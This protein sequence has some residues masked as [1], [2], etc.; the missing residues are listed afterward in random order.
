MSISK[1]GG[2]PKWLKRGRAK[3]VS[4]EAKLRYLNPMNFKE[5]NARRPRTDTGKKIT[6]FSHSPKK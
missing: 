6:K 4:E 2:V 5:S 1:R 3:P